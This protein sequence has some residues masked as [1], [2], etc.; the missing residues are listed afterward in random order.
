[1]MLGNRQPF[2]LRKSVRIEIALRLTHEILEQDFFV[3]QPVSRRRR[4]PADRR[5]KSPGRVGVPPEEPSAVGLHRCEVEKIEPCLRHNGRCRP[6]CKRHRPVP[7]SPHDHIL[8][9]PRIFRIDV[10]RE[11]DS[12]ALE[13]RP[14]R[15][16]PRDRAKVR[17]AA[18]RGSGESRVR[19]PRRCRPWDFPAP[20][21]CRQARRR[22]PAARL[23]SDRARSAASPRWKAASHTNRHSWHGHRAGRRVHRCHRRSRSRPKYA[24]FP[25]AAIGAPAISSSESTA[26]SAG[27]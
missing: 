15:V 11:E 13:R 19:P 7:S 5:D 3:G 22:S 1:M 17:A 12:A 8:E 21:P 4:L 2:E 26:S 23:H 9:L 10:L 20:R 16:V 24:T 6:E 27:R 25:A 14:I 18:L